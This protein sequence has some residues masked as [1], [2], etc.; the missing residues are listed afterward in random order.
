M[1]YKIKK[2]GGM[3]LVELLA[4]IT[5]LGIVF[6]GFVSIFPQ[7]TKSNVQT[8]EKL[9]TMNLA[10]VELVLLKES[11]NLLSN[12][13]YNKTSCEN[14]QFIYEKVQDGY[15]YEIIYDPVEDL[16]KNEHNDSVKLNQIHIKVMKNEKMISETFGYLKNAEITCSL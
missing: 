4:A 6:I 10:R 1:P 14:P 7:M 2:Q 5:I 16:N 9:E 13:P 3:T 12:P 11:P 15:D 8:E